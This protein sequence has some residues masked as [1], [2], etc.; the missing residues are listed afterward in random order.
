MLN[1][2]RAL[3]ATKVATATHGELHVKYKTG[4]VESHHIENE[5]VIAREVKSAVKEFVSIELKKMIKESQEDVLRNLVPQSA[6]MYSI[7]RLYRS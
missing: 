7:S 5:D 1:D 3:T 6:E 4:L 2:G